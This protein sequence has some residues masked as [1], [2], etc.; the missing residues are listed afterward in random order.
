LKPLY[1]RDHID[2][3]PIFGMLVDGGAAVNLMSYSIFKKL[4]RE[5]D[6][7]MMTNLTLNDMGS[8]LMEARGIVSMELTIGTKSLA[9]V[10][11]VVEVQGSKSPWSNVMEARGIVSIVDVSYAAP[12]VHGIVNVALHRE[13]SLG[14]ISIFSHGRKYL[15]H[16]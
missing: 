9:T 12:Q 10:F 11:F 5:D 16:V 14:I 3:R 2:E 15:Y 6:E 7:L 4:G 1:I 13:Y 8:N